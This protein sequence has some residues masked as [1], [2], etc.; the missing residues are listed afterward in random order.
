[1]PQRVRREPARPRYAPPPIPEPAVPR[2]V[3]P[4]PPAAAAISPGYR[5]SLIGWIEAHK[6]YPEAAREHDEEGAVVLR[7]RV[8]RSGSVL[9]CTVVRSS[10]YVELDEAAT[11][12]MRGAVLPPFPPSMPQQ[13]L[14]ISVTIRFGLR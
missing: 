2:Y 13:S 6:R 11:A 8:D 5:A 3:P 7:F 4:R 9:D 12:M 14:T 10:G 1:V